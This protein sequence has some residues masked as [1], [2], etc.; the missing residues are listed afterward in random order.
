MQK[1]FRKMFRFES[2]ALRSYWQIH[3][4]AWLRSGVALTRHCYEHRLKRKTMKRWLTLETPTPKRRPA[5]KKQSYSRM[6]AVRTIAFKAFW[7]MHS[8][9]QIESGLTPTQYANAHRLPVPRMRRES[10]AFLLITPPQDWREMLHPNHRPS[11]RYRL[12]LRDKLRSGRMRKG[13]RT[14]IISVAP[15]F[16]LLAPPR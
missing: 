15:G 9:A 13:G 16:Q 11:G 3:V 4:Y 5:A 12:W 6:P 14:S 10:R 8:E 2:K 7:M 1:A